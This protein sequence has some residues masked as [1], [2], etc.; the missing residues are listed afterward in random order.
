[1]INP[2]TTGKGGEML[3]LN[4]LESVWIQGKLRMWGR[5]SYIG[6]GSGGH[7]FNNL[8]ASKKVSKT[9]IQQ[10]LKHLKSSGLD[11]GELMSYFL[12]M[13]SGKEKSNLA[14]CTDEEGL[15]MDAVIGEILVRTG[16]QRLFKLVVERYKDR[17]SKKAMAREL[18]TRHPEWCLRT[19]ES[20]IDVWLQ[21]AEAMLYLPMCDVFDKKADRF[22]LQSC[23]GIA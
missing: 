2:S 11:H 13:L 12:D 23:A 21:M 5:W 10:V 8:L 9:A 4:T 3:R 15:L 1:M 22:R 14:F 16:H 20:R 19:C 17:M 7:M 18:N 6:S